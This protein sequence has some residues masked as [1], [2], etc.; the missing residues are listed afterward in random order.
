MGVSIKYYVIP[1]VMLLTACGQ[2]AG[3]NTNTASN[4]E[5]G[6]PVAEMQ[7]TPS[8]AAVPVETTSV[9][10]TGS[11]PPAVSNDGIF[12]ASVSSQIEPVVINQFHNWT[13]HLETAD[14]SPVEDA[15][16]TVIGNMP[17]HAHGMPTSPQVT[18]NLG[19]GDYLVEGMQFQ[20][21]GDWE[22]IFTVTSANMTDEIVFRLTL[23]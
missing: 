8:V 3:Q 15:T 11:I 18:S 10:T 23:L 14:G 17:A 4:T 13:L 21:G 5:S 12:R 19:N 6:A 2:D 20:M 1:L 22:V 7:V 9:T 16:I